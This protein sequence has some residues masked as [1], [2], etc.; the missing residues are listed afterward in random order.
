MHRAADLH[1]LIDRML[2][3]LL[4]FRATCLEPTWKGCS[5]LVMH[6]SVLI[7]RTIFAVTTEDL[8]ISQTTRKVLVHCKV[9]IHC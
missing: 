1:I 4:C 5:V 3:M 6:T 7:E 9:L 8:K 2:V